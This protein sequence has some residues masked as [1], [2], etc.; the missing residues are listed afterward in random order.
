MDRYCSQ[1]GRSLRSSGRRT[2]SRSRP[3]TSR[4]V[5]QGRG[6][7]EFSSRT[8]DVIQESIEESMAHVPP[9][10]AGEKSMRTDRTWSVQQ[11]SGS[12]YDLVFNVQS[13]KIDRGGSPM[14]DYRVGLYYEPSR[15]EMSPAEEDVVRFSGEVLKDGRPIEDFGFDNPVPFNRVGA[16]VAGIV[17]QDNDWGRQRR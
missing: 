11:G 13:R 15:P 1:C 14:V 5:V 7:H 10:A 4:R 6:V 3:R 8:I 12:T 17:K 9:P 2:S 16:S